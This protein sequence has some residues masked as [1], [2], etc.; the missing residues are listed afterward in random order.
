MEALGTTLSERKKRLEEVK[1]KRKGLLEH[2]AKL[3]KELEALLPLTLLCIPLHPSP[4]PLAPSITII[5]P[6]VL[7]QWGPGSSFFP[8]H[9][10]SPLDYCAC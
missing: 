6:L 5:Y 7:L 4:S 9:S 1:A 2:Q 8:S 10:P 3:R